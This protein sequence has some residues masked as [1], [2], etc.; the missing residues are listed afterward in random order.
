[1]KGKVEDFYN[2]QHNLSCCTDWEQV[3][4]WSFHQDR[5]FSE[6]FVGTETKYLIK[7]QMTPEPMDNRYVHHVGVLAIQCLQIKYNPVQ[8]F[9]LLEKKS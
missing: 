2:G 8:C 3:F 4:W 5:T 6:G 1:M 7:L 9:L